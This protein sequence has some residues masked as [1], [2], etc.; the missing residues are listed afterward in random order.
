MSLILE[1]LKTLNIVLPEVAKP[2]A[3][4]IS[5]SRS[6]NL[7]YISGQL[8]KSENGIIK[9]KLGSDISIP[10][11]QKA[12][13]LCVLYLI[14]QIKNEIGDLDLIKKC[15]KI[16]V[17][18][19]SIPTFEEHSVVANGASDCMVEILGEAGKHTRSSFGV[20][21]LPFG[22]CVEVEAIFEVI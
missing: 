11:G 17:F 15:L 16:C 5:C 6:G 2:V 22:A 4:Y 1:K 12:A 3:N 21:S 7:I 9:G 18:V 19:N 13:R 20:A 8:P 10:D 14:S